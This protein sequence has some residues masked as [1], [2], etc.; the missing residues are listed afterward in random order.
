MAVKLATNQGLLLFFFIAKRN[1]NDPADFETAIAA[2]GYGRFNYYLLLVSLAASFSS[3]FATTTMSYILPAAQCDLS[4]SL[5][6]KGMLNACTY[7]GKYLHNIF[8]YNIR[9]F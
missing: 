4:L 3:S 2:T 1:E 5:V 8:I 7:V 6:D 9:L